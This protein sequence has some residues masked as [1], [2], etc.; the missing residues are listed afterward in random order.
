MSL[1]PERALQ[2][3]VFARLRSEAALVPL[4]GSPPRVYDQPP[5][6]PVHPYVSFG[7]CESRPWGGSDDATLREGAEL[8]LTLTCVSR[9]GGGEEAKAVTAAIRAALHDAALTLTDNRLVSLRATY[10]DIFR[11]PDWRFTLGVVRLRAVVEPL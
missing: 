3:A 10:L 8:A 11:A 1:D 2:A 5:P 4:L 6:D 9:F 7:R